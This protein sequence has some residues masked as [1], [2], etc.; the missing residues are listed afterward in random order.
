MPCAEHKIGLGEGELPYRVMTAHP[1]DEV[2]RESLPEELA[3][4]AEENTRLPHA[5]EP[6]RRID[7]TAAEMVEKHAKA[8]DIL[9]GSDAAPE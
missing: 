4:V 1:G 9:A 2:G 5:G 6:S 3:G 7:A 8:L